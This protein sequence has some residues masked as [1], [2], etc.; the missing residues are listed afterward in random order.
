[1]VLQGLGYQYSLVFLVTYVNPYGAEISKL[2]E[3]AS[4]Y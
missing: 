4:I 3:I 1:M 2:T